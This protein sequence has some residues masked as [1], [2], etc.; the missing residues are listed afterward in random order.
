MTYIP[1]FI[2]NYMT[3]SVNLF[4]DFFS[5]NLSLIIKDILLIS[6]N[7]AYKFYW[8]KNNASMFKRIVQWEMYSRQV[9]K[10]HNVSIL[11]ETVQ[12]QTVIFFNVC[13]CW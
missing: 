7:H 4:Q 9:N 2:E 6:L 10:E 5:P 3:I 11:V 13:I 12:F 8:E 1:A